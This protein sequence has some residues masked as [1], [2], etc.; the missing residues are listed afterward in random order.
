M[1][2]FYRIIVYLS[3]IILSFRNEIV[4]GSE[5]CLSE[6]ESCSSGTEER[7]SSLL[8]EV[9]KEHNL[10]LEKINSALS[11][12]KELNGTNCDFYMNTMKDD[13]KMFKT[14]IKKEMIDR[15][16]S[17]GTKY[18][19]YDHKLYR[20][21]DCLFPSRCSGIE[22]FLLQLMP[23]FDNMELIINTRDWPQITKHFHLFGPVFSF[24]KTPDYLDI[25]YPAWSFWEGG[26][27][28]SIYPTG[29]GRWDL[30]RKSL[31]EEGKKWPW[32]KKKSLG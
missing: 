26:P 3:V 20:D 11:S 6:D 23:N 4:Q 25:M 9:R 17:K 24:S 15:V 30:H 19:I 1:F 5:E 27:A 18:L 13:L 8:S 31:L 29:L 28:I 22:H 12:Y 14:G 2:C 10:I 16:R 21:K 32:G 7:T